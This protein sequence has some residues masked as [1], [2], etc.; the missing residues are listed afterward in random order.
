M[1]S[2]IQAVLRENDDS[3]PGRSAPADEISIAC[4]EDKVPAFAGA[5]IE[6]LYGHLY[7]SLS[8]FETAKQL[9]GASTYVARRNGKPIAVLLYRRGKSDVTVIS[10]FVRLDEEEIRRFADFMFGTFTSVKLVTFNRV[11]SELRRLPYPSHAVNCAEDMIVD[12][13]ATVKEYE[14]RVGKNMR[15]NIKRYTGALQQDFPSYYYRTCLRQEVREQDIRDIVQLSCLR[16]ESKNIAPRFTE[17]ETQ[18]IVK[19]AQECGLVGIA[20][21]DGRV[22]A[23]AIGFRIGEN[24][25]MHVIAHDPKYNDYSLGILCYYHT[26]CEGIARGGKLFHL[27]Q[28]RYAYKYRLK[29]ER[30]DIRHIDIYRDWVQAIAHSRRIARKAANG[31]LL[32]FKQ[33]LLHDVERSDSR[34]ARLLAGVV[35]FLR[36]RRRSGGLAARAKESTESES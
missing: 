1:T 25:F 11:R 14:A 29:A 35:H 5:E 18:W 12:L 15:R 3:L 6:R 10:E 32:A 36:Q 19:F 22:C 16:M 13:P 31:H 4:Y 28:G 7:C 21:I 17:E 26:I 33:W 24:Y 34:A 27:L 20:T 30:H 23:G 9:A 8:Y 2:G